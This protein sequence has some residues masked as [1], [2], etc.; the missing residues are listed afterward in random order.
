VTGS[1]ENAEQ[2][3]QQ[4]KEA[5]SRLNSAARG[6]KY[7]L[8]RCEADGYWYVAPITKSLELVIEEEPPH[9]KEWSGVKFSPK[10]QRDS[11]A[12]WRRNPQSDALL[13]ML[14]V[15]SPGG[16]QWVG[17][18]SYHPLTQEFLPAILHSR[19]SETI[20]RFGGSDFNEYQ[21]GIYLKPEQTLLLR[22]YWNP[23]DA[24]GRFDPYAGFDHE[25]NDFVTNTTLRMLRANGLPRGTHV[26]RDVDNRLVRQYTRSV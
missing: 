26:I 10:Q 7:E 6:V 13:D 23:R 25:L 4:W 5:V 20:S 15:R 12:A 1:L 22:P 8:V 2:E 21:R 19:H 17:R 11:Y 18:F 24:R 3:R 16:E 9:L 14:P